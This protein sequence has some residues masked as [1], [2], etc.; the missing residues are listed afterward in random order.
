[1]ENGTDQFDEK[2]W[3]LKNLVRVRYRRGFP[4]LYHVTTENAARSIRKSGFRDQTDTYMTGVPQT[5][6][7]FS[8][9]PL[10][11]NEGT[12]RQEAILSVCFEVSLRSLREFEWIEEGKT[13]REWCIPTS[14]IKKRGTIVN[15]RFLRPS[16]RKSR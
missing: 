8:N 10:D 14:F 9:R 4:V 5:G 3:N 11:P 12:A 6:V 2:F 7:F 16:V 15:V 13:Y 1:M